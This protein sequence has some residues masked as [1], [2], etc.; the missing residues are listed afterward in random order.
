MRIKRLQHVSIGIE[1]GR[2]DEARQFY[3]EVLGLREKP[4]PMGLKDRDL[5]WL[6]VGEDEHEIHLLRTDP[7]ALGPPRAAD[8]LCIEVDD[9]TAMRAHLTAKQV[10]IT[11][12]SVIDNRPRFF[13]TDP[14]GN[15]IELVQ[16]T[17]P[18]TPV[19]E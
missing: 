8:H 5:I 2:E 9:I 12:T 1:A 6:D 10:P 4:R 16:V 13:V 18:F 7:A 15:S 11:E 17:G 19:D 14:F 3:G